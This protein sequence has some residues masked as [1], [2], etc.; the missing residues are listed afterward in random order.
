MIEQTSFLGIPLKTQ[1]QRRLLVVIYYLLLF[2]LFVLALWLPRKS[3]TPLV[4]QTFAF[5]GLLGGITVGGPVKVFSPPV[6][7]LEMDSPLQSLN[8]SGPRQNSVWS[9]LD[10][11]EQSQRD[12]AHYEAYRILRWALGFMA[13]AYWL[14]MIWASGWLTA[15][16]PI[17]LWGL[18]VVV[19]SLPQ[20]V[21]LWTE[22]DMETP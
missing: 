8:L 4:I 1:R 20:S 9:P 16:A 21:V 17:L 15:K 10:E 11:R 6:L 13:I 12:H 18:L 5:G 19:L 7:P 3:Y 22:L 14:G 2:T